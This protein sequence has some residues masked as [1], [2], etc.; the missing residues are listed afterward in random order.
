MEG[1]SSI[2]KNRP[3]RQT[4]DYCTCVKKNVKQQRQAEQRIK[5]NKTNEG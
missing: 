1:V 5:I 3:V 2:R 4:Q